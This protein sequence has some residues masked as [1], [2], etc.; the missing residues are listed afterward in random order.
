V[1]I[2]RWSLSK[3]LVN[4]ISFGNK[5]GEKTTKKAQAGLECRMAFLMFAP[6]ELMK[7]EGTH[8]AASAAVYLH[9]RLPDISSGSFY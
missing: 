1:K 4:N 5:R 9:R 3:R 6:A 8:A 2:V 7:S